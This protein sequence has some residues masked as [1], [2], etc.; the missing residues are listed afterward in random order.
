MLNPKLKTWTYEDRSDWPPFDLGWGN[1]PDKAEW[2]DELTNLPCI[3]R[4][5][6]GSVWCGYVAVE[7]GHPYHGKNPE[8]CIEDCGKSWCDHTPSSKLC[9]HGGITFAG[10]CHP[11]E[12]EHGICHIPQGGE[13]DDVWWFGFDT[14]H[15][16]D[17]TPGYWKL[18]NEY[19][20]EALKEY[21]NNDEY[22]TLDYVMRQCAH[23]AMQLAEVNG[24]L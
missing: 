18:T 21:R 2:R 9:A 7:P 1:E 12:G 8:E 11:D 24:D 22:R 20:S 4:R 23:L 3:A 17:F 6:G 15:A 14:A 10:P 5:G 13:S 16:G 19:M